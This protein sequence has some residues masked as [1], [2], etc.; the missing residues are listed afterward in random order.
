MYCVHSSV[1][2]SFNWTDLPDLFDVLSLFVLWPISEPMLLFLAPLTSHPF[3]I[4]YPLLLGMHTPGPE[5]RLRVLIKVQFIV[6]CMIN[7]NINNWFSEHLLMDP[8]PPHWFTHPE[9]WHFTFYQGIHRNSFLSILLTGDLFLQVSPPLVASL[10]ANVSLPYW[11]SFDL[12]LPLPLSFML[13]LM[14]RVLSHN[15]WPFDI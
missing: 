2:F 1:M 5:L 14:S 8:L 9:W 13:W 10:P 7:P 11:K 6:H 4:P 12:L 15:A 3:L